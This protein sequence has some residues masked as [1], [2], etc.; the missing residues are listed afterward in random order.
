MDHLIPLRFSN[1]TDRENN[2]SCSSPSSRTDDSGTLG[3]LQLDDR[4]SIS[5]VPENGLIV[6]SLLQPGIVPDCTLDGAVGETEDRLVPT[7]DDPGERVLVRV[8]E[9]PAVGRDQVSIV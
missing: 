5:F 3:V 4:A 9:V 2:S 8:A 7:N 6:I 1:S